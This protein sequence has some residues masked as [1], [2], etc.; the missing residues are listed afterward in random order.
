M[1]DSAIAI[2]EKN[3]VG[4]IKQQLTDLTGKI[5]SEVKKAITGKTY[6]KF[7]KAYYCEEE[8]KEEPKL[9]KKP[10]MTKK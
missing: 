2:N 8:E 1:C 5:G 10:K 9:L 6:E 4:D 3:I 7:I